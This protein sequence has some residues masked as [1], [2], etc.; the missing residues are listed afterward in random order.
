[1]I[2]HFSIKVAVR[3]ALF[4]VLGAWLS[5]GVCGCGQSSQT[6]TPP[7]PNASPTLSALSPVSARVGGST[8]TLTVTGTGFVPTSVVQWNGSNR[9]TTFV[10]N[11][12]IT[13]QI[14]A[15]DIAA[16]GRVAITVLTP[17]PGGGT[18]TSL[19]FNVFPLSRFAYATASGSGRIFTLAAD[20]ASGRLL[21]TGYAL[22]ESSNPSSVALH[23]S[24]QFAYVLNQQTSGSVSMFKVDTSDGALTLIAPAMP[25]GDTPS[26]IALDPPGRF[27]YV[28]NLNSGTIS[29]F[30]IEA[31]TG[32]LTP[33]GTGTVAAGAQ[34]DSIALDPLGKFVFVAN[35]GSS[36][37]SMFSVNAT[38][39]A[40]SPIGAGTVTSGGFNP[41]AVVVDPSGRFA[42]VAHADGTVVMFK[43][44]AVTG[45]LAAGSAAS[46]GKSPSSIA[47]D[48]T[49]RFAYVGNFGSNDVSAFAINNSTGAL[50][51]LGATVPAGQGPR[52][53][54][55]DPSGSF[56]YVGNGNGTEVSIY[57]VNNLSGA[58]TQVDTL[59]ARGNP[60]SLALAQGTSPVTRNGKFLYVVNDTVAMDGTGGEV[61]MY[62]I[63]PSSG[64][65]TSTN[66][67]FVA[68]SPGSALAIAADPFGRFVYVALNACCSATVPPG[69]PATIA[70]FTVDATTGL[71]TPTTPATIMAG[72]S[73]SLIGAIS[74]DPTGRFVYVPDDGHNVI[75]EYAIT[76]PSGV[77]TPIG[78]A[79]TGPNLNTV[80]VAVEPSG[81]FLYVTSLTQGV[82]MFTINPATGAL[83]PT[84]P[85]NVLAATQPAET[86][87]D[88]T[89]KFAYVTNN[90]NLRDNS[91]VSM[92]TI[93][94]STGVLNSTGAVQ[95]GVDPNAITADPSGSFV[96]VG[97]FNTT[98]LYSIDR[99]TGLLSPLGSAGSG[100]AGALTFDPSGKFAYA[101]TPGNVLNFTIDPGTGILSQVG[102]VGG[103]SR[104]A[105]VAV[106]G[107]TQ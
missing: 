62:T 96:Y 33:I 30:A 29:M 46:A 71:L 81:T 39:G 65:L 58:L 97:N 49:G 85:P 26:A 107:T 4:S 93:D 61:W 54:V 66:P 72:N 48:P 79:P 37:I 1:M 75:L 51:S 52:T 89:G 88:P 11:T 2:R 45:A 7:P 25:A 34:P 69:F 99:S 60:A 59:P 80:T 63:D 50:T 43:I 106:I 5:L 14:S 18:S 94:S 6:T 91:V 56:V 86:A 38:G 19:A 74:V 98:L 15:S 20:P 16:F 44:D 78:S 77:L 24:G 31:T 82:F 55:V 17:A 90:G 28:A 67:P 101:L 95:A 104:G 8:F 9:P 32:L 92:Y 41:S 42:Y 84:N 27:A 36:N 22:A 47:I 13:A 12:Q 100:T 102:T 53:V 76:T 70:M 68:A 23:S 87:V 10:S 103:P 35:R 73:A 105:A 57:S 3:L 83:T 40:L 21:Y 64:A